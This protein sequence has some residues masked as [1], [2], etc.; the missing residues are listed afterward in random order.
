MKTFRKHLKEHLKDAKFERAYNAEKEFVELAVRIAM[1]RNKQG[2]SQAELAKKAHI[3][4][5]QL[6]KV[7]NGIN[8]NM[9][10]FI[11]VCT[12]LGLKL[13]F[14]RKKANVRA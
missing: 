3:T 11:R 5:Q 12:A 1:E 10:T 13:N 9:Q 8:C 2:I 6:S 14:A 4:Q 7:E